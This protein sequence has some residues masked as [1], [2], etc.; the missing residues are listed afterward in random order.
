MLADMACLIL[1]TGDRLSQGVVNASAK[2]LLSS[3]MSLFFEQ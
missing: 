2:G 3:K 1:M